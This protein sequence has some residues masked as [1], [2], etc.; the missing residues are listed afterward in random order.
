MRLH[1]LLK[2]PGVVIVSRTAVSAQPNPAEFI[3][4][5][6][7]ILEAAGLELD[8]ERVVLKPNLTTAEQRA[9]PDDG[10][11]THPAFLRGLVDHLRAHGA[12]RDRTYVLEDP[13]DEDHDRPRDWSRTGLPQ[14]LEGTGVK[15]RFP[16]ART[17]VRRAVSDPLVHAERRVGRLAVDA[18]TVLINVPKLKTHGIAITTLCVK[19]LMGLDYVTDRHYCGQAIRAA[20]PRAAEQGG[21]DLCEW[22]TLDDHE[23]VQRELAKRLIDLAKVVRPALN[24]VEGVVGRDGTG[25][26]RG[27]NFPLGVCLAGTNPVTVDAFASWL[28]GFDPLKLIYL[29]EAAAAGLGEIDPRK[30]EVYTVEI[31]GLVRCRDAA[32]LRARPA[33]DAITQ[34]R[35]QDYDRYR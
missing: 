3:A 32:G 7:A 9:N 24:V 14:A 21:P 17:I 18:G 35:E 25:F 28:M 29:S 27:R 31:G 22:L 1:P 2:K 15:L 10:I 5:G 30:I 6:R 11:S 8:G 20:L 33:F 23:K 26:H 16:T 13:L 12:R 19:N 34:S 4:A